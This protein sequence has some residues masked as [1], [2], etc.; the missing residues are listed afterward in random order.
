MLSFFV[1]EATWKGILTMDNLKR[2][3]W[4]LV[5]K[6]FFF[7]F[8]LC[9]CKESIAEI[10]FTIPRCDYNGNCFSHCLEW[11]RYSIPWSKQFSLVGTVISPEKEKKHDRSVASLCL[12]WIILERGK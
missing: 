11:F 9:K 7:F 4:L 1:W 5:N 3:R 12:F 6:C 2:R 10:L 8:F